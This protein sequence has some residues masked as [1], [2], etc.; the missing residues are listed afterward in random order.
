[1]ADKPLITVITVCYNAISDIEKTILSVIHQLYSNIEYVIIDGGS[2]DGT[3][4]IIEK[5]HDKI[6]YWISE[7]DKG[8]Y[9]A[10]NKGVDKATGEWVCF[11]NAGDTF[12]SPDT[13]LSVSDC[14]C[15]QYDIVYGK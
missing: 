8:I 14:F 4:E 9:D 5:Y 7:S 12:Y 2:V 10:M 13:I 11:M 1:M 3:I 15:H 6:S